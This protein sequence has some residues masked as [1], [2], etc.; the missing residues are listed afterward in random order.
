MVFDN[1]CVCAKLIL[2]CQVGLC[3]DATSSA[4]R[5]RPQH[6]S[7][8]QGLLKPNSVASFPEFYVFSN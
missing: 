4:G 1:E 7:E 2:L 6:D 3:I 5:N 8:S